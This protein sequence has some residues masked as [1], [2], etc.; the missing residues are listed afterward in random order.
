MSQ[1]TVSLKKLPAEP[2]SK[3]HLK[4][5]QACTQTHRDMSKN[6]ICHSVCSEIFLLF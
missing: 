6:Y 3:T 5:M 4:H 1:K 2:L